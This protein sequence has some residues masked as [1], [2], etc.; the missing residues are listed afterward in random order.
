MDSSSDISEGTAALSKGIGLL[1]AI[2]TDEG[3][4]SVGEL[5][6]GLGL[7]RTTVH[8]LLA[9]LQ[10]QGLIMRTRR[11]RYGPGLGLVALAGGLSTDGL[12]AQAARE[13]LGRLVAQCGLTAHLGILQQ[14]MVT[15][16]VKTPSRR[17]AEIFTK[18]QGQLEAYCSGLGKILLAHLPA[19]ERVAYLAGGPFVPLTAQTLID[20]N[21]IAAALEDARLHDF[22]SDEG[23]IAEGLRCLA[24]PV[25]NAE[26]AVVAAISVSMTPADARPPDAKILSELRRAAAAIGARLVLRP[27]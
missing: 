4:T 13:P 15:Y 8:R 12:L 1:R 16:L 6:L 14:D 3:A 21:M 24:V 20:P 22:V 18:E 5:G 26:N 25:R 2:V 10:R 9:E 23:E 19:D 27:L 7:S 11:G 17:A